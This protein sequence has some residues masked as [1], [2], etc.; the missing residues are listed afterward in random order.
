MKVI[1]NLAARFMSS[2]AR[3]AVV[4]C[5]RFSSLFPIKLTGRSWRKRLNSRSSLARPLHTPYFGDATEP[6]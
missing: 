1:K 3:A 6:A 4:C 2:L 5:R